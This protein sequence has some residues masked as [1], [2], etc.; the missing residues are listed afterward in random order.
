M[1]TK[2]YVEG[3]AKIFHEKGNPENAFYQAKYMKNHFEF[4]GLKAKEWMAL[5]K[6]YF[7]DHGYPAIP[8]LEEFVKLCYRYP[9]REMHYFA[10]TVLEKLEK[11]LPVSAID[12]FEFAI[13]N[14]SWWDTVDWISKLVGKHLALHPEL[15]PGITDK[16]NQSN[17]LWLVRVSIIFQLFYRDK[18]DTKLLEKYILPYLGHKDFFIR[19]AIGW[20]LR[21]YSKY[22][23]EFVIEFVEQHQNEMSGLSVREAIRKL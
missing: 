21:H 15:Q 7:A 11:K 18:T 4:Y 12:I 14:N 5:S 1:N 17:H 6:N 9:Q 8:E 13:V 20:A 16:F 10:I 23:P 2:N 19:K 3:I 22:N